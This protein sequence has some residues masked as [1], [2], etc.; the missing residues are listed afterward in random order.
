M[1][2]RHAVVLVAGLSLVVGGCAAHQMLAEPLASIGKSG[3]IDDPKQ[4]SRLEKAMTDGQIAQLLDLDVR[5]KLPTSLAVAKLQSGCAGYQP[6]LDRIDAEEM[7]AWEK[8]AAKHP[9]LRGVQPISDLVFGGDLSTSK[10]TLHSL[11]VAAAKLRCELLLVYMQAD[12]MVSNFNDAAVLYWTLVGLWLVPGDTVEHKTVMQ[13]IVVDCRTGMILGTATGD[14]HKKSA[15][16]AMFADIHKAKLA[17]QAP[18]EAL[19]DLQ[20]GCDQLLAGVVTR[21]TASR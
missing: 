14:S 6:T 21:A 3:L 11:R 17:R 18:A 4:V 10:L 15:C 20:Q 1:S 13:A 19:G 16:P 8:I 5:A 12:S 9:R 7:K 2:T